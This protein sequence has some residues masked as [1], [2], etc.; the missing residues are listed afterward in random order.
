MTR[1]E[2]INIISTI[3]LIGFCLAMYFH[4]VVAGSYLGLPYPNNTF[5]FIPSDKFMDLFNQI[6]LAQNLNPYINIDRHG[7]NAIV[8]AYFPFSYLTFYVLSLIPKKIALASFIT[9][10]VTSVIYV[11]KFFAKEKSISVTSNI[12]NIFIISLL[13]YPFLFVIDRGNNEG[14]VFVFEASFLILYL[15]QKFNLSILFLALATAM[16]LYPGM[17]ALLFLNDK[18]Y[19]EFFLCAA[20][21]ILVSCISLLMFKGGFVENIAAFLQELKQYSAVYVLPPHPNTNG[22]SIIA[23][24]KV[25]FGLLGVSFDNHSLYFFGFV[26]GFCIVIYGLIFYYILCFENALWKQ[27]LII[28]S[29]TIV[30]FN[31]S[32][33]YKMI[34][35]LLPMLVYIKDNIQSQYDKI[36]SI[37]FGFLLIPKQIGINVASFQGVSISNILNPVIMMILIFFIVKENFKLSSI[38]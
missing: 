29:A 36:Y 16:K 27:L 10:F 32:Y 23:F 24:L 11:V 31:C 28:I 8:S 19:K 7:N 2:K 12:R 17:L 4:F 35:L 34:S 30:L 6:E 20:I 18:K 14:L 25:I 13:T 33:D 5:L 21:T 3:V 38:K 1:A 15:K 26:A 37:G 9:I 22:L